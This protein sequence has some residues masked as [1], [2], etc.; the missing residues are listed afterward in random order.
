MY[1]NIIIPAYKRFESLRRTLYSIKVSDYKE[2]HTTIVVDGFKDDRYAQLK[3]GQTT[4]ISNSERKGWPGSMNKALKL[5]EGDLFL[6][7]ADDIA[8]YPDC[9]SKLVESMNNLYPSGDGL[10]SLKQVQ[11]R[12]GGA[13]GLMGN[14]FV[15]RFPERTVFCPDYA[16][17]GSDTELRDFATKAGLY[18][19]RTDAVVWHDRSF[20]SEAVHD[21][22]FTIGRAARAG[23]LRTYERRK[24]KRYLWGENFHRLHKELEKI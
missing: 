1:V 10:I 19:Y 3:D 13:F 7:G 16:H 5:I 15:E 2:T 17:F 6:Y 21:E 24:R 4:L 11:K 9:I 22:A 14:K 23:D 8:F 18:Y 12:S 20:R